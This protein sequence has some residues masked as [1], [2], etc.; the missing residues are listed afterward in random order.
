MATSRVLP[1]D[2]TLARQRQACAALGSTLYARLLDGI[3][4]DVA[5]GGVCA[6]VLVPHAGDSVNSM[7]PLRFLGAVHRLVLDGRA[8]ALAA[9]YPSAG[10]SP[11]P[12]LVGAFLATVADLRPEVEAR[13][14]HGVQT[15]EVGRSA[16]LVGG[17]AE[18]ARR[19]GLPL[20]VLEVGASAG[21]N[22]RWDRFWYDT[23]ASTL[24]DPASPVRFTGVWA[25]GG[26]GPP[27]LAVPGGITVAGR[28]GC[29]RNPLDPTTE[30]GR[31]TL[32]SYLW[33]DQ[34]ARRARLDAALAVAARVPARVT[35]ADVGD[36][37][38]DRLASPAT[39]RATVVVHSIVWQYILPA[40]RDR[41]REA[42]RR[43]GAAAG[44]EAPLAW[45]RLEPAGPVADIRLTW[46][47]GG[48]EE[49]L[50]T[51]GYHG[52]DVVWGAPAA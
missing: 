28:E 35:R 12:D 30:E 13:L 41:M 44:P 24:G 19:S 14:A 18:V 38:G 15:N 22:L 47:P 46:W 52:D 16:A 49:V 6:A 29:D 33:P 39:G 9:Q 23:G 2:E 50:G 21:L 11:G 5:A 3:A 48:G 42:L 36:W 17:Y 8:P 20:R 40:S 51:A 37:L 25:P 10:G 34:V 26:S 43:R 31:R 45:L 27:D 7:L 4:A 1:L 32:R